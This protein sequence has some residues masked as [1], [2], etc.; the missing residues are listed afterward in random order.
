MKQV[1]ANVNVLSVDYRFG[2]KQMETYAKFI[3]DALT[4]G[5]KVFI[6]A[7]KEARAKVN[8]LFPKVLGQEVMEKVLVRPY[9][10]SEL[11]AVNVGRGMSNVSAIFISETGRYTDLITK[12]F[13]AVKDHD[14]LIVECSEVVA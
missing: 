10:I 9:P 5:R 2:A 13:S 4:A 7:D 14:A 3:T 8:E 1:A 12:T 11:T 6:H